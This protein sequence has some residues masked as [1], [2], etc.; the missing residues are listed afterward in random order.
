M[1]AGRAR[2]PKWTVPRPP[3]RWSPPRHPAW[4]FVMFDA[5]DYAP[6]TI[7]ARGLRELNQSFVVVKRHDRRVVSE[8]RS[9][10]ETIYTTRR[11]AS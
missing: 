6:T 9:R 10:V 8:R 11:P 7:R 5:H 3:R 4:G 1:R 2:R